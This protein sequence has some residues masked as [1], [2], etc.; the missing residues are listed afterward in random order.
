M[1][2][3]AQI[4]EYLA[5]TAIRDVKVRHGCCAA[6]IRC[7]GART[8]RLVDGEIAV[9]IRAATAVQAKLNNEVGPVEIRVV[10]ERGVD[11]VGDVG[12]C[13]GSRFGKEL[14]VDGAEN[15]V[16]NEEAHGC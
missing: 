10:V 4:N 11:N 16:D 6:S 14:Q 9:G 15:C 3:V 12:D 2:V 5:P 1:C 13:S 7:Y 8:A